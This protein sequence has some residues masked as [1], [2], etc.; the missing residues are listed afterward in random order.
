MKKTSKKLFQIFNSALVVSI[1]IFLALGSG[2]NDKKDP[3]K[4]EDEK[5][6]DVTINNRTASFTL[7]IPKGTLWA[8]VL[9]E[10]D[11]LDKIYYLVKSDKADIIKITISKTCED[12]YGNVTKSYW[13]KT[14]DKNWYLWNEVKKY[15]TVD[16]FSLA[17]KEL[18]PI[19]G[20]MDEGQFLCC[21]RDPSCN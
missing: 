8:Q 1:F 19:S 4:D 16:K 6:S 3:S 10:G 15:K 11:I 2:D 21:G 18:Y 20:Q 14:I 12:R 17:N 9:W 7:D 13:H 5:L